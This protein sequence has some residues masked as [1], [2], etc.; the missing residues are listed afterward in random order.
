[1]MAL[2]HLDYILIKAEY[3]E[4]THQSRFSVFDE[5]LSSSIAVVWNLSLVFFDEVKD[6]RLTYSEV[7][8]YKM[9]A[10]R[11]VIIA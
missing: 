9:Q 6:Q 1:M 4:E 3:A 7:R 11:L 2:A 5:F 8:R 10:L